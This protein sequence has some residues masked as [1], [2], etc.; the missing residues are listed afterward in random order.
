MNRLVTENLAPHVPLLP[1]RIERGDQPDALIRVDPRRRHRRAG[2][3]DANRKP[4]D[5][6]HHREPV[7]GQQGPEQIQ[8]GLAGLQALVFRVV[9]QVVRAVHVAALRA[10]P[11]QV[12]R[13]VFE[14]LAAVLVGVD[15]PIRQRGA[16]VEHERRGVV[17][18]QIPERV[19]RLTRKVRD[20]RDAPLLPQPR[21]LVLIPR[22][23]NLVA[24][25]STQQQ[26]I[27]LVRWKLRE[28]LAVAGSGQMRVVGELR[29]DETALHRARCQHQ[30]PRVV[31]LLEIALEL[32]QRRC[33][34][35]SDAP[36]LHHPQLPRPV[37]VRRRPDV[38]GQTSIRAAASRHQVQVRHIRRPKRKLLPPDVVP[39]SSAIL[40]PVGLVFQVSK[41]ELRAR[42]RG[43]NVF[44]LVVL[45]ARNE[46]RE[47]VVST[48]DQIA[49]VGERLAE[50]D[51]AMIRVR[52]AAVLQAPCVNQHRVGLAA[53]RRAAVKHFPVVARKELR[54]LR[55]WLPHYRTIHRSIAVSP[56]SSPRRPAPGHRRPQQALAAPCRRTSWA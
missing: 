4:F 56:G 30:I 26:R 52:R 38:A 8:C 23:A 28:L 46:L 44:R 41:F 18:A 48:V 55:R 27:A 2:L 33:A 45:D 13:V 39:R 1:V 32:L 17:P 25:P 15:E 36:P 43:E 49:Q 19:D 16:L 31:E 14:R 22:T 37:R 29:R 10:Q 6:R 40:E 7:A 53:A 47:Q 50:N 11:R 24:R 51:R 12:R 21:H 54:L 20:I 35:F 42:W 5:A 34:V 9:W 3:V